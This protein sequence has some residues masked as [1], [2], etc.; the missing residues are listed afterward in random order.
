MNVFK[1]FSSHVKFLFSPLYVAFY[2]SEQEE[3]LN[4]LPAILEQMGGNNLVSEFSDLDWP[5]QTS[6]KQKLNTKIKPHLV[7]LFAKII[8]NRFRLINNYIRL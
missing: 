1:V 4:R 8:I 2:V 3:N 5:L 7:L 6:F